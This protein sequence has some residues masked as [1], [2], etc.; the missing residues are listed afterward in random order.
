MNIR[1][2]LIHLLGGR[3]HEEFVEYHDVLNEEL[4][5]IVKQHDMN[6]AWEQLKQEKKLKRSMH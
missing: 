4:Q 1:H 3:T 6:N 5:R 2:A